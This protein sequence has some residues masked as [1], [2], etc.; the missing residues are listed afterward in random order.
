MVDLRDSIEKAIGKQSKV[1]SFLVA[2]ESYLLTAGL[3]S[4]MVSVPM[5][6]LNAMAIHCVVTACS[7]LQDESNNLQS[8]LFFEGLTGF[9]LSIC[10]LSLVKYFRT[11]QQRQG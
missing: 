5:L 9:F 3:L 7:A 6:L 2:P 10:I 1:F 11:R 8:W 4:G